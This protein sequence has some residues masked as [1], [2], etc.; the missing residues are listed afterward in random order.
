M[1]RPVSI[2]LPQGAADEYVRSA[3]IRAKLGWIGGASIHAHTIPAGKPSGGGLSGIALEPGGWLAQPDCAQT[4]GAVSPSIREIR[5]YLDETISQGA[6]GGSYHH[7][8]IGGSIS[9][10]E[11][12]C[13]SM[14]M[15]VDA[16]AI[17]VVALDEMA[18]RLK[19]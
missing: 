11:D 2:A 16:N 12:L 3:C 17:D 5:T 13:L 8:V 6:C 1:R 15:K 9:N 14:R 4:D 10:L 7:D 18:D 19:V